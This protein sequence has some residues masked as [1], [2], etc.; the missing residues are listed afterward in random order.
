MK[1]YNNI[2]IENLKQ[3]VRKKTIQEIMHRLNSFKCG[4]TIKQKT[5]IF[6]ISRVTAQRY[7]IEL[8]ANPRL[9]W[10]VEH[11]R[12]LEV[13]EMPSDL[14]NS[15]GISPVEP[16]PAAELLIYGVKDDGADDGRSV[17][18]GAPMP[19]KD[20]DVVHSAVAPAI[21]NTPYRKPKR[22]GLFKR[23]RKILHKHIVKEEGGGVATY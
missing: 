20:N 6:N 18:S 10:E 2:E 19:K 21:S 13:D 22:R 7:S 1:T 14:K 9:I 8:Q 12:E 3:G 4:L 23:S 5:L 16:P 11:Q 15:L 17:I